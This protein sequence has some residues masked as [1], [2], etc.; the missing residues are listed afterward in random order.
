MMKWKVPA[1]KNK[2]RDYK[3]MPWADDLRTKYPTQVIENML[4]DGKDLSNIRDY[5]FVQKFMDY[6]KIDLLMHAYKS[7]QGIVRND[8][9]V[10]LEI[11]FPFCYSKCT[12]CSNCLYN[13]NHN[14]HFFV[15]YLNTLLKDLQ[16]TC[17]IIRKKCY[18]VKAI[19]F[20]GDFLA[21]DLDYIEKF[22]KISLFPLSEI[23]IEVCSPVFIDKAKLDL[24]KNLCNARFIINAVTFNTVSLRKLGRKYELKDI[25]S[26]LELFTKLGIDV[27]FSFVVGLMQE[28]A[29]QLK[30]NIEKAV[31]LGASNINLYVGNCP[32]NKLTDET[33]EQ[34]IVL[35]RSILDMCNNK[36]L[37]SGFAPYFLYCTEVENGCFENVGYCLPNKKSK[38]LED[39]TYQVSTVLCCGVGGENVLVKNL[40]NTRDVLPSVNDI[41]EYVKDFHKLMEK[42]QE[43]FNQ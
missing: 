3:K 10:L 41:Y 27:S 43:F 33:N 29:L 25:L 34:Q 32:Y 5:F 26:N 18:I 23:S 4:K 13:L 14:E 17:E 15:E 11:N 37:S 16:E 28:K 31:E 39:K 21:L 1:A 8:N 6:R 7:V 24:I 40:K 2:P 12:N 30:R 38:Y 9:E 19:C 22:L 20:K 42:K 36:M 35:R